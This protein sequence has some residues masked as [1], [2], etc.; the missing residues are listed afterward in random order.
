[1]KINKEEK[2]Q[3]KTFFNIW[4]FRSHRH[5]HKRKKKVY[6]KEERKKEK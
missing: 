6:K 5:N 4:N 2:K 1:M 3:E